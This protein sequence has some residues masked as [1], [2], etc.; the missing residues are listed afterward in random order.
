MSSRQTTQKVREFELT[1]EDAGRLAECLNSFDDSDSWPGGFTHGNPFT[2]ER[3][4]DDW[5]KENNIR[6]IVGYSDDKIVGHCNVGHAE[7]D[8]EACYVPLL[9]VD[10]NFQGQGFGKAMLIQAAQAAADAGKRRIDLHTWSGNLKA[11]PLY[12]RTGYN[13]VPGTKVLMESHIPGILGAEMFKEF[14]ERHDWYD[15]FKVDITQGIDDFVEDGVGVFRYNFEAENGDLLH[16]TVDREAKGICGFAMTLAGDT[17]SA[18]VRPAEHVGYIGLGST[19]MEL[20]IHNATSTDC[21][22]TINAQPVRDVSIDLEGQHTGILSPQDEVTLQGTI[23]IKPEA[24]PLDKETNTEEKAKTQGEFTITLG[25][26]EIK[27]YSGVIPTAAL[28]LSTGPMYPCIAPGEETTIGIGI[29]NNSQ[30]QIQGEIV[31]HLP[32]NTD[33]K[34]RTVDFQL[35]P[36]RGTEIPL[37]LKTTDAD[38]N[39]VLPIK[40]SI[41]I[42]KESTKVPLLEK[43]INIPII[44]ASGAV[45]YEGLGEHYILETESL[46]VGLRKTPSMA[47][48][49]LEYKPLKEV[50]TGWGLLPD[51]GYP[52]SGEGS[53]WYKTEFKVSMKAFE[54]TAEIELTAESTERPGLRYTTIHRI[55]S[56]IDL[57]DTS[58]K[59]ENT[60]SEVLSNLGISTHA[61]FRILP[62]QMHV[63]LRNEIVALASVDW[64]GR[65]Q[66]SRKPKE[67]H[68]TWVATQK[69]G[70]GIQIGWFWDPQFI[71]DVNLR[72]SSSSP[73]FE[74]K[75][76]DLKPG[77][78]I[79]FTPSR[80]IMTEGSWETIRDTWTRING[81]S[82]SSTID[83]RATPRSDLEFE[84]AHKG[85]DVQQGKISPVFVDA[86]IENDMEFRLRVVHENPITADCSLRMPTGLL[87]NGKEELTFKIEEVS[88]DKSFYLP[89]K[90]TK[91]GETSWFST[92]GEIVLKFPAR[93]VRESLD[94]VIFD[95]SLSTERVNSVEE[96]KD[97]MTTTIGDYAIAVSPQNVGSLVRY[98]K[99]GE[100]SMFFD[101]FPTVKPFIWWDKVYSGVTPY[102][103]G[104]DVWDWETGLYKEQWTIS[105]ATSGSWIGYEAKATLQHSPGI[106]GLEVT[107][108]FLMLSGTPLV[109][110]EVQLDNA[111]GLWKRPYMGFKGLPTPGGDVQSNIHT[112]H[113]GQRIL[114]ETTGNESDVWGFPEAGWGA[115]EGKTSGTI[116]GVVSTIKTRESLAV[117]TL[118]IKADQLVFRTQ[119]I[120]KAGFT[121]KAVLYLFDAQS[122]EQVELLKNLPKRIE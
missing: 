82:E 119:P 33:E 118:G 17:L 101:T 74:Y 93:I 78:T 48:T 84:L 65:R 77:D 112:V 13:W 23:T 54:K 106:K 35:E 91:K 92:G 7:L 70:D 117:D 42:F 27:L 71:E 29:Q 3:V 28:A 102:I 12:K 49:Y 59:L 111:S 18:S 110:L 39:T 45:V 100:P 56:G 1:L 75:L 36:G 30:E 50:V 40:T 120:V 47:L 107:M 99:N 69:Q 90:V 21:T 88:I 115:Y 19:D 97:L 55:H 57:L 6:V 87:A 85:S 62:D 34:E 4:L 51:I 96:E 61:W 86:S 8:A 11:V 20:K 32:A 122:I 89:I 72:R 10:P 5:S 68:E 60:G 16:V 114:Y 67:Y 64:N 37:E 31:F 76:P 58:V 26:R 41:S 14:F 94:V 98:G 95:S 105:E 43:T 121:A 63:P 66:I 25:D 46:R 15:S 81:V 108:R 104:F 44:G 103:T 73:V 53:E 9:G 113:Q 24:I 22:Y 83:V 116:L 80:F 2:A 38:D 79:E 52:F 109:R